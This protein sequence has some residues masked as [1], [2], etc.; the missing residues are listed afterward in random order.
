MGVLRKGDHLRLGDLGH[1][2]LGCKEW[3]GLDTGHRREK[4]EG[5]VQ[6]TVRVESA[7]TEYWKPWCVC[8]VVEQ[9]E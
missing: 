2:Q 8:Y 1:L 5:V 3:E 4:E 9:K 7:E 6:I